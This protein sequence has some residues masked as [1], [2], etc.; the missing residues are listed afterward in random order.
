MIKGID[1]KIV[2]YKEFAGHDGIPGYNVDLVYKGKKIAHAYDD[3]WGG[4]V[5][6]T[7]LGKV[8]KTADSYEPSLELKTNRGLLKELENEISALPNRESK[9]FEDGY[10]ENLDCLIEDLINAKQIEKDFKKGIVC[11]HPHGH[12]TFGWKIQLPTFIEK[13]K[14]GLQE[15][16]KYYDE[17]KAEGK[18]ILN[19]E[20]LASIGVVL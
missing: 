7:P 10:K 6:I 2:N 17:L 12:E 15:V 9:H 1:L 8:V 18:E 5:Q 19:G 14:N 4:E 13:Y 20:Y 3:A 11:K 16:Q